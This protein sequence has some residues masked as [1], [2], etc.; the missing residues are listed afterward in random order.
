LLAYGGESRIRYRYQLV[1]FDP[2]PS[3]WTA[4]GSKEYTN[5]GAGDYVFHVWGSDARGNISGPETITFQIRSAPW[6]TPWA[7]AVYILAILVTA[8]GAMQWRVRV[9][10][11]RT[12]QLEAAVSERTKELAAAKDQLEK[13]AS[14]D[15]LTNVANR[16][17][18][19]AIFNREWKRA[20]RRGHWFSLALLDVDFFKRFNDR[21]GHAE[22]DACLRA[23]AQA[24]STQCH[25]VTDLVARYGGEEFAIILPETEPEGIRLMLRSVLSAVDRLQIEHLDSACASHVTVSLGAVSLKPTLDMESS[26]AFQVADQMLYKAKENGRHQA[27]YIDDAVSPQQICPDSEAD[28][29]PLQIQPH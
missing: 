4:S 24:V 9:L 21:Y 27:M 26:H 11:R 1:G 22:G 13:L 3:E 25:R 20:Q 16:R 14:T 7:Y 8:Y 15:A 19:D 10:S 2:Q 17:T 28:G 5:L 12:K 23:V 18:F 29:S 6:L